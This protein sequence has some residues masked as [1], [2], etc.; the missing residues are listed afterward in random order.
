MLRLSPSAILGG[1]CGGFQLDGQDLAQADPSAK[2]ASPLL[3]LGVVSKEQSMRSV[4]VLG[5]AE[6][7]P[8]QVTGVLGTQTSTATP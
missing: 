7:K 5:V 2:R 4:A 1:T 6:G 8:H 3:S